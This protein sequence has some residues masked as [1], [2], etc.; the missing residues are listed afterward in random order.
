M[1]LGMIPEDPKVL[2]RGKRL[3]VKKL[4]PFDYFGGSRGFLAIDSNVFDK[5][6]GLRFSGSKSKENLFPKPL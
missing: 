1:K 4:T 5:Y 3:G 2:I 6:P